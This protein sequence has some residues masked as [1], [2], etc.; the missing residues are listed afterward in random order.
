MAEG[1]L[2]PKLNVANKEAHLIMS[3]RI[4]VIVYQWL[5]TIQYWFMPPTCIVCMKP[6]N[7]FRDLCHACEMSLSRI[8]RPCRSC[9]LP[10]PPGDYLSPCCGTCLAFSPHFRRL[11][12]PYRYSPPVSSLVAAYKYNRKLVNGKVLS[13]QLGKHL[14]TQY[15]A[16]N[17]PLLLIPMPLHPAKLRKR[18]F[19]QAIE[20][21]R[22]LGRELEIPVSRSLVK[23]RKKTVQQTGLNARERARNVNA[24]FKISPGFRFDPQT[25]VAIIDDVVT[26]GST[27]SELAK[28]LLKAG[29]REVHVWALA[30]TVT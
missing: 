3:T 5:K 30:R 1:Q 6:A 9:G 29:A 18:G 17:F 27:V 19:N 24:A 25:T 13:Q 20:I 23:R 10:L 21:A 26:T 11:I 22:C 12:A 28:L 8:E 15:Q 16:D 7:Q 14:R 4:Q 2:S